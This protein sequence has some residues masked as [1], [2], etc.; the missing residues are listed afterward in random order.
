MKEIAA[1]IVD[2]V[3]IVYREL[4]SYTQQ[5]LSCKESSDMWSVKEIVGH[6]VDSAA[7]NHQRIVR[8]QYADKLA[9]SYDQEQ[10]VSV[11]GYQNSDFNITLNLWYYY[12]LHL[13]DL[14]SKFSSDKLAEQ[15]STGDQGLVS[16]EFVINDYLRHLEHHIAKLGV[17][18]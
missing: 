9:V 12:N 16:I 15:I 5:Q 6:L 18:I 13:A 10:W 1:K 4:G 14:I 7:N 2:N 11:Q 8:V 3:N 17:A